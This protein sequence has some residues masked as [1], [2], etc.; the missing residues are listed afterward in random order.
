MEAIGAETSIIPS[1]GNVG[2]IVAIFG[3]LDWLSAV[4][5][6]LSFGSMT[7]NAN[8]RSP[9]RP[10][11]VRRALYRSTPLHP[12]I[13]YTTTCEICGFSGHKILFLT[14]LNA[15]NLYTIKTEETSSKPPVV[16]VEMSTVD[17]NMLQG[18]QHYV[19]H[20]W[21]R[22]MKKAN[23]KSK[24]G[25]KNSQLEA[26]CQ[27]ARRKQS[28]KWAEPSTTVVATDTYETRPNSRSH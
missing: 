15:S 22:Q 5:F 27:L 23:T 13:G 11:L 7:A 20:M 18:F 3:Y 2:T 25:T 10:L 16:Q 8:I 4:Q 28:L 6:V 14:F 24:K 12:F 21:R 1:V 9:T 19:S 26:L 17:K